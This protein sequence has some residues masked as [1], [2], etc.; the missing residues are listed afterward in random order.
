MNKFKESLKR[1][2]NSGS[3]PIYK[4]WY[5]YT[6]V[7]ILL[8]GGIFVVNDMTKVDESE[9]VGVWSLSAVFDDEE[10]YETLDYTDVKEATHIIMNNNDFYLNYEFKD[11]GTGIAHTGGDIFYFSWTI[12][13]NQVKVSY[14]NENY[15]ETFI[16]DNQ[17]DRLVQLET[18]NSYWVYE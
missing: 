4:R 3:T 12:V 9:V 13:D 7:A 17:N 11:D 14:M 6:I 2:K 1:I 15:V 8:V 10:G 18:D 16:Y 5:F